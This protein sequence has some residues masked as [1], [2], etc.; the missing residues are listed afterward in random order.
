M[1]TT[2][3]FG[4]YLAASVLFAVFAAVGVSADVI[5]GSP[6]LPDDLKPLAYEVYGVRGAYAIAPDRVIAVVGPGTGA[7]LG[8]SH[9]WRVLSEDDPDYAYDL[10]VQPSGLWIRAEQTEFPLPAG[11]TAPPVAYVQLVRRE[12]QLTLPKPLKPGCTYGLVALG[13]GGTVNVSAKSG[14]WFKGDVVADRSVSF[15]ADRKAADIVGLRRASYLG[16]GKLLCEFGAGFSESGGN[17]LSLYQVTVNGTARPVCAM[18]RRSR[19]DAY[20]CNAWPWSTLRLHDIVLDIGAGL[21]EGD[22]VSVT[23]DPRVTAGVNTRS[24]TMGE[25][26]SR[27][28]QVNQVGYLPDGPKVAYL[29][30]WLGSY[31]DANAVN[32]AADATAHS[33]EYN[34]LPAWALRFDAPPAFHVADATTGA[35]VWSGTARFRAAGDAPYANSMGIRM[36]L[37]SLNVYELDFSAFQTPGK[38]RLVVDG[39]GRSH[40]FTIAANVYSKAFKKMSTGVFAQRCGFA[41]DPEH[42]D[43]WRRMA[44]HATGIKASTIARRS[45]SEFADFDAGLETD[46]SGNP[47]ILQAAGGHHDAGD[48]NPRSHIDVAQRLFWAYELAPEKFYDG[49]LNIPEAG[50]GVPD[51]IDEGLWAVRLWEG[52]QD[53]DG[54]VYDG[55]ESRGDPSL[56]QTVELD[57][58]GDYAF[59]KDSRGSFWAAGAF[60]TSSRLLAK[61]GKTEKAAEYLA[62]ARRAY[63]WG[64]AHRPEGLGEQDF[65]TYYTDPFLYAAA[66]MFHTT[67]EAAYHQDFLDNC[68]W[69]DQFWTEMENNGKWD[70]KLAAQ[71]YLLIPRAKADAATWDAVLAAMRREADYLA[72]Y[73]EQRDYPFVTQPWVQ[74]FWGFGAYQRF[75]PSTVTMWYLTHERKYFDRIVRNCD[76]TLGANPMNLSWIVGIGTETVRAPLHNSHW[77]PDGFAVTGTQCE[78]PVYHPGT[79]SFSY[80]ESAYPACRDDFASMNSFADAHFAVEMDEGVVNGQAETMAVFGLL[81]PDWNG[82]PEEDEDDDDEE[83]EEPGGES[84]DGEDPAPADLDVAMGP[85]Y[86]AGLSGGFNLNGGTWHFEE[87]STDNEVYEIGVFTGPAAAKNQGR[88]YRWGEANFWFMDGSVRTCWGGYRLWRYDGQMYFDGSTYYFGE[89]LNRGAAFY[90]DGSMVWK[91]NED[92]TFTTR[93]VAPSAGWHDIQIRLVSSDAAPPGAHVNGAEGFLLGF[94]YVKSAT[95]PDA[96]SALYYPG[97]SG[98]GSLL[99]T[100]SR[101]DFIAVTSVSA[102][103]GG[104]EIGV[105]ANAGMPETASVR[106]YLGVA[107]AVAENGQESTWTA[108]SDAVSLSPGRSTTVFVPWSGTESP[109]FAVKAEGTVR[110]ADTG[111]LAEGTSMGFWQWAGPAAVSAP[112]DNPDPPDDPE[113]PEDPTGPSVTLDSAPASLYENYPEPVSFTVRRSAEESSDPVTVRLAYSGATNLV[114]ALPETIDLAAGVES[115]AVSFVAIDNNAAD[116]NG[117]FTVRLAESADYSLGSPD[118]VTVAV[119][120]DETWGAVDTW[121]GGANDGLWETPANWSLGRAPTVLDTAVFQYAGFSSARAVTISSSAMA[122]KIRLASGDDLL[123]SGTGSLT[124]GG[125]DRNGI[126]WPFKALDISVPLTVFAGEGGTN[127]WDVG[128]T[129]LNINAA[130]SMVGPSCVIKKTGVGTLTLNVSTSDYTDGWHI[131]SGVVEIKVANGLGGTISIGGED[132]TARVNHNMNYGIKSGSKVIVLDKGTL[133]SNALNAY[134]DLEV[135]EGGVASTSY[136]E[137]KRYLLHGGTVNRTGSWAGEARPSNQN[138]VKS[139]ASDV[140]AYFSQNFALDNWWNTEIAVEDGAAPVDLVFGSFYQTSE[141]AKSYIS[142]LKKTGAGTLMVT[143]NGNDIINRDV[144]VTAGTW[145]ADAPGSG[146]GHRKT[147]VRAGAT[148]GGVGRVLG[149]QLP[150]AVCVEVEGNPGAKGVVAPGSLDP[151]TGASVYG[152]LTVGSENCANG[153]NFGSNTKLKVSIGPDHAYTRLDVYGPVT[154]GSGTTLEVTTSDAEKAKSGEYVVAHATGGFSA[155]FANIVLPESLR[156]WYAHYE[157]NSIVVKVPPDEMILM[158]Q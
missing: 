91:D 130:L 59:A 88:S 124:V 3:L 55:T 35:T 81:C 119:V 116:G 68:L 115:A 16:D 61:F 77:R 125:I 19:L 39:V 103:E 133:Y 121:T 99:R 67:E 139:F 95:A 17:D 134:S 2:S 144:E 57:T 89:D 154:V 82:E 140:P 149:S 34:R 153:V 49:Q 73:C 74:I 22:E 101:D 147:Y 21:S 32:G 43:G 136:S 143:T 4:R 48:Y 66:E 100:V 46:G 62:R 118:S 141:N 44:C 152:T 148:L 41:L 27:A 96:M 107:S 135:Y 45:V 5:P 1:K 98:D 56:C 42:A 15:N 52:L 50:N 104:Y 65:N 105:R 31:P 6:D 69:R 18:G 112:S 87:N 109:Y 131:A 94:G 9:A 138:Y 7:A 58:Q 76:N 37:S 145:L 85:A 79:T 20:T 70:R 113:P 86:R 36:N 93:S 83:V 11:F 84:G 30:C 129:P 54:G 13:D 51:I 8:L 90:L 63:D 156:S 150:N 110:S 33:A 38:Y 60:A 29:G 28:V 47:K 128:N 122:A 126:G 92:N 64:K 102:A 78:G 106:A 72:Q 151:V 26:R 108:Q 120:D 137:V 71:S 10:F 127:V 132:T 111:N 157:N 40:D 114:S 142:M 158:L 117:A 123:L 146:T 75:I 25:V 53:E 97:D 80:A 14:T 155:Q 12:I 23:V 24:F